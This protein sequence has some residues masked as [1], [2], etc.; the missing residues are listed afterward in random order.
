MVPDRSVIL[1]LPGMLEYGEFSYSEALADIDKENVNVKT[2]GFVNTDQVTE[3][4]PVERAKAEAAPGYDLIQYF[5]DEDEDVWMVH[6][7][8]SDNSANETYVYMNGK[9]VTL[10]VKY[11]D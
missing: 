5:Y 4:L 10:L 11:G 8:S 9:G 2:D 7:F 1:D 3:F 6:F